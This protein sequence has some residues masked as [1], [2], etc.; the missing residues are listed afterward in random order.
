MND[1]STTYATNPGAAPAVSIV[2]PTWNGAAT[3]PQVLDA[4]RAQRTPLPFEVVAVDSGSQDETLDLLHRH[5]VRVVHIGAREF[6]H[7]EARNIGIE[8]ARGDLIVLLVQDAVPASESWLAALTT[9]LIADGRV[10]GTF[11]RQLPREDASPITRLYLSRYI[12]SSETARVVDVASREDFD[13]LEPHARV[14]R[15]T[16]DNVC[17]CIRRSVWARHPFRPTP[18]GEDIEWA[19]DV[20]LA[21]YRVAFVPEAQV[22]HSHDRS[23]RYEFAR[24]WLL[25]RR[26]NELFGLRTIPSLSS[27]ARAVASS[28]TLHLKHDPGL[29]AAALAVAWPLGQYLGGGS[30]SL[31]RGEQRVDGV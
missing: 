8:H 7:G 15:C 11:A 27:L 1:Y 25:H 9:L 23:A 19:R 31:D 6:D 17:S 30:A 16:F 12:A 14:D 29:R 18:I 13:A 4:I 28:L 5:S 22:I 20:L 10:A 2:I 21:G 3:L 26:L 24:T